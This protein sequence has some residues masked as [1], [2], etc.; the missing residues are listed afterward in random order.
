MIESGDVKPVIDRVYDLS[1][2]PDAM[3]Y[4]ID[5]HPRG[6]VVITVSVPS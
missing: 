3:R 5:G 1:E 6:K 4:L 2:T